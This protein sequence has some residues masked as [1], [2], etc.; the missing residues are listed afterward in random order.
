MSLH[1]PQVQSSVQKLIDERTIELAASK[2]HNFTVSMRVI[3]LE[4]LM[5][6]YVWLV[7]TTR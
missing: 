7:E 1:S 3:V 5:Q 4:S 6:I 2:A